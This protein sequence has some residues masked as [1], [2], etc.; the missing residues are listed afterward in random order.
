[1]FFFEKNYKNVFVYFEKLEKIVNLDSKLLYI[2]AISYIEVGEY[3][4]AE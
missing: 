3:K 1:L 2:K 4:R